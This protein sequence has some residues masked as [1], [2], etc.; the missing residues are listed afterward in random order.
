VP[1]NNFDGETYVAFSDLNGF[2]EM[3]QNHGKAAKALDKLYKTVYE[4]KNQSTYSNIQTLAISDC[5][6]SFIS[7]TDNRAQLALMLNFLKG[8]HL[9]MIRTD[10]LITTSVA[11]GSFSY[12]ERIE[13]KGL[14]KNMLY[15]DAY[16]KAYLNNGKCP[17]GSIV[18][19]C[20]GNEKDNILQSAGTNREF[21]KDI[22]RRLKGL[23]YFWAVSSSNEIDKF[24]EAYQDTY[25][26]KYKRMISVYKE[27]SARP[28]G[29]QNEA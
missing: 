13:I 19:I 9:E 20:E 24:E 3:M 5:A 28:T 29:N 22:R 11:Y 16:L 23:Q 12:H 1:I 17:E 21:L 7:N 2:K 10:Y 4:L 6:I 18:I 15:G 14:E 27:Y 8:L 25:S 26:L